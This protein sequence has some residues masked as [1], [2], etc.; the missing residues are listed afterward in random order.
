M[1]YFYEDIGSL[2]HSEDLRRTDHVPEAV[3][4]L[5]QGL[6]DGLPIFEN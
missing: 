6:S 3:L 4:R 2:K 1:N 5:V